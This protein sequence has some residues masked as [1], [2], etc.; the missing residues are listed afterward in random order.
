MDDKIDV[1][2]MVMLLINNIFLINKR[3]CIGRRC[4]FIFVEILI[5]LMIGF[6]IILV[7]FYL[8]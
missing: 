4:I 6:V 8:I 5:F 2:M 1:S 7:C 3:D